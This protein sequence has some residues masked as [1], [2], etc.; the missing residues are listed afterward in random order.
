[1]ALDTVTIGAVARAAGVHH[2]TASRALSGHPQ[3]ATATRDRVLACA[4][5]LGY[6]PDPMLQALSG[7]RWR[8]G[9]TQ[10]RGS[11]LALLTPHDTPNMHD[12]LTGAAAEAAALGFKI[13]TFRREDYRNDAALERVLSNRGI[14]GVLLYEEPRGQLP[15]HFDWDHFAVVGVGHPPDRLPIADTVMP[16]VFSLHRQAIEE[17]WR[18]GFRRPGLVLHP[19][20]FMNYEALRIGGAQAAWLELTGSASVLP[21]L[22]YQPGENA[23]LEEWLNAGNID[24]V[25]GQSQ[26]AHADLKSLGRDPPHAIGFFGLNLSPTDHALSGVGPDQVEVGRQAARLLAAKL[27]QRHFG[28][29]ARGLRITVPGRIYHHNPPLHADIPRS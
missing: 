28:L 11:V 2:S 9:S 16:D 22:W 10:A 24:V 12:Q 6:R 20:R 7:Y 21:V 26:T 19:P 14:K 13:E 5:A 29:S 25:L 18:Q 15:P 27:Q 4:A 23:A 1:M 3:I 8:T 17:V